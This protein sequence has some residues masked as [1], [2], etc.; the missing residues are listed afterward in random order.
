MSMKYLGPHF[1]IH[2]GRRR[3]HL[4]APRER[5]RPERGGDGRAV[6]RPLD[7]RASTSSS[8]ARRWPSRRATSTRSTT[9][10]PGSNDPVAVRY[11]LLSVPYRK[12]L[13][14][15]W[16]ALT[17]AA[18]AVER[19]RSAVAADRRGGRRG[20]RAS[21][22]RSRRPSARRQ[23]SADF[24][25]ALDDDL[26]TAEALG[27]LFT[28]LREINAALVENT[29]DAAGAAAAGA[30]L[31][32]ADCV[33]GVLPA[34][35]D[36]LDA[37]IEAHDRGPQR[38]PQVAATSPSPTGSAANSPPAASSSRTARPARGGSGRKLERWLSP[39]H[40]SPGARGWPARIAL[41]RGQ[42]HGE[43]ARGARNR[44]RDRLRFGQRE[45]GP[46]RCRGRSSL[47]SGGH[48]SL[49]RSPAE[50]SRRHDQRALPGNCGA[51][52]RRAATPSRR[53]P[54][55]SRGSRRNGRT[56]GRRFGRL[57]T[58]CPRSGY[59]GFSWPTRSSPHETEIPSRRS[60]SLEASWS[61]GQPNAK[62]VLLI[63]RLIE[64][65]SGRW[66]VGV[67]RK[68]QEPS[69][70][71]ISR[72]SE[73]RVWTRDHRVIRVGNDAEEGRR[74]EDAG[75]RGRPAALGRLG[76]APAGRAPEAIAAGLRKL[77]PCEGSN[78]DDEGYWKLVERELKFT[79][80]PQ[81]AEIR[82]NFRDLIL[83]NMKDAFRRAGGSPWT[84]SSRSRSSDSGRRGSR[85][86]T[87]VGRSEWRTSSRPYARHLPMPI[88][89]TLGGWKSVSTAP[90]P[91]PAP[92]SC[93]R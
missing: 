4:P 51:I 42:S 46:P 49:A 12:K 53:S 61:L 7:A 34:E 10:S 81:I 75:A 71:W 70:V 20:R 30:A 67:L 88:D 87:D 31:R 21:P 77:G 19:I 43:R 50:G 63:R 1:D 6:R 9:S 24:T 52:S 79:S 82:E 84:R 85:T 8:T 92:R 26:N 76:R 23:F 57:R 22:A 83:I 66:Q 89:P 62:S 3:Q 47:W 29:L 68:L 91:T 56:L 60:A 38:R 41:D 55:L 16:E 78:L 39:P 35:D 64:I 36:A 25:A 40:S 18:S 37:E 14:F 65:A 74:A 17:G 54:E 69:P 33:L 72:L 93:S 32:K 13:N 80:D 59:R 86:P 27:V 11:L 5:D 28:F 44:S 48:R 45:G 2:T 15:T 90:S 58:S 73:D